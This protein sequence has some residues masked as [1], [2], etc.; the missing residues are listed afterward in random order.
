MELEASTT[1][2]R[3]KIDSRPIIP[4][5]LPVRLVA[6]DD[7]AAITPAGIEEKLDAFYVQMLQFERDPSEPLTYHADNFDL[8]FTIVE[9]PPPR[10]DMRPIGIEVLSLQEAEQ[11]LIDRELEYVRQ[12]GL[13]SSDTSL[14]LLDPA[15]NWVAIVEAKRVM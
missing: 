5:P 15:G 8:R 4:E 7:V 14:L 2:F 12:R 10:D 9:T 1:E 13:L 11:K 6:I 3:P